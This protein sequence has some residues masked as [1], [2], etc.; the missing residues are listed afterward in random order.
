MS[1]IG[2]VATAFKPDEARAILL[3]AV[4]RGAKIPIA[5]YLAAERVTGLKAFMRLRLYYDERVTGASEYVEILV[6][7]RGGW[8][9]RQWLDRG[10]WGL[11]GR[12]RTVANRGQWRIMS[13]VWVLE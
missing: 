8:R 10:G 1:R 13:S 12:S 7:H 11:A 3:E 2:G 5:A 6:A 4:E 9:A